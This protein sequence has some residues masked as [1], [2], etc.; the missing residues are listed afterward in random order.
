MGVLLGEEELEVKLCGVP[1]RTEDDHQHEQKVRDLP[2]PKSRIEFDHARDRGAGR[3][4]NKKRR[5]NGR[6]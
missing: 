2:Q 6:F 5:E 3:A 4:K 1:D